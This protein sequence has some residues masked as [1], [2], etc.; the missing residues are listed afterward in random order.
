MNRKSFLTKDSNR[1]AFKT[2]Q[3]QKQKPGRKQ[4]ISQ[5]KAVMR[6]ILLDME[7]HSPR[8]YIKRLLNKGRQ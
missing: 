7:S 2:K 8:I 4:E 3:K 6:K 5:K 1:K